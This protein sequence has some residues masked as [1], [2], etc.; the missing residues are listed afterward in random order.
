MIKKELRKKYREIRASVV[1]ASLKN[2]EITRR[3]TESDILNSD[4]LNY[5]GALKASILI[6]GVINNLF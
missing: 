2:A 3:F 4:H 1:G 6:D 5:N